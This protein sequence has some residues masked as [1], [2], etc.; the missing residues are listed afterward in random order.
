MPAGDEGSRYTSLTEEDFLMVAKEL[1]V[2]LAV[3]KAVVSIE[4]GKEMKG[5]L[6]SGDT[7]CELRP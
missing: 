1:D 2:E 3:I 5:F 7:G 4:A 6:G